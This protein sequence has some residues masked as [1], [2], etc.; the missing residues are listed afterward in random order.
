MSRAQARLFGTVSCLLLV[1]LGASGCKEESTGPEINAVVELEVLD[2]PQIEFDPAIGT[3]TVVVQFVA[4]TGDGTP[5]EQQDIAVD[6]RLDGAP[7]DSEGILQEDSEQLRSNMY[8]SLVLD[9]SYSMLEQSPPAFDPMLAAARKTVAAGRALYADRPGEFDWKLFWFS[10]RIFTPLENSSG[11]EWLDTDIE[12]IPPPDPGTFT[13]LYAATQVAVERSRDFAEQIGDDPRDHH[14]I[15]VLS[16]G[17]DNYSWFSNTEIFGNGSAG[18]N[19]NYE[20]FG[21]PATSKDNVLNTIHSHPSL[22]LSV[23]GLGSAVEDAELQELATAGNGTYFKNPNPDQLDA[24]FHRVALEL[25]S[26]QTRGVTLPLPSG[27][28][29]LDVVV[30]QRSTGASATHSFVFHGGDAAAGPR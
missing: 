7:V 25:T 12:R 27:D 13:K 23:I 18:T 30:R 3:T 6:L 4:R 5:L 8:L 14:V 19:R 15:V 29:R 9:A 16:D 17:A 10:D 21:Y 1:S 22:R 26:I 24:V 28:Y 20:Y 2:T 11:T